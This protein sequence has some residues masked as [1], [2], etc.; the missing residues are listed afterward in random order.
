MITQDLK[1]SITANSCTTLKI[2]ENI[3]F[4]WY[5]YT[6]EECRLLLM[7]KN[8]SNNVLYKDDTDPGD[9]TTHGEWIVQLNNPANYQFFLFAVIKWHI[10]F[11]T[12]GGGIVYHNNN[13][14]QNQ[15]A[16]TTTEPIDGVGNWVIVSDY[17]SIINY[18]SI[19]NLNPNK[20]LYNIG[21]Y[22]ASCMF[23]K[24]ANTGC[25]SYRVSLHDYVEYNRPLLIKVWTYDKKTLVH[26]EYINVLAGQRFV[27]LQ[28]D[29]DNVYL[30]EIGYAVIEDEVWNQGVLVQYTLIEN[31]EFASGQDKEEYVI[32]S[33]CAIETCYKDLITEVMCNLDM[34]CTELCDASMKAKKEHR[35]YKLNVFN[36]LWFSLSAYIEI[37][38]GNY[39]G[40]TEV[41]NINNEP[42]NLERHDYIMTVQD[43]IN[44]MKVI[45][46]KCN[47]C[48]PCNCI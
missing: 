43:I 33:I 44:K 26:S 29:N 42:L 32:Y 3:D 15:G 24:I 2:K 1:F 37:E 20:G 19:T 11:T 17:N 47:D 4:G 14:F 45:V 46:N 7:W 10:G 22:N 23:T 6:R 35:V 36:A 16:P 41:Y 12:E 39:I 13:Y 18:F 21:S 28:T 34:D 40:L 30:L 9:N 38:K 25:N 8:T 48:E 5:F 31:G 27:D